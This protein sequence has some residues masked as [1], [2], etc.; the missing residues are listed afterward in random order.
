MHAYKPTFSAFDLVRASI[1]FSLICLFTLAFVR[2]CARTI[3]SHY[4]SIGTLIKPNQTKPFRSSRS[5]CS[6][7]LNSFA[8]ATAA[9]VVV[10][11]AL[12]AAAHKHSLHGHAHCS[13]STILFTS[14][15]LVPSLHVQVQFHRMYCAS[16]CISMY[17]CLAECAR[18]YKY[19]H[20]H[21]S[22]SVC[23]L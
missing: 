7:S 12:T 1:L 16:T 20:A 3:T 22:L 23:V 6:L 2:R 9:V 5:I 11:I 10:A 21:V 18:A 19:M 15:V 4:F 17:I 8:V 13:F 14:F